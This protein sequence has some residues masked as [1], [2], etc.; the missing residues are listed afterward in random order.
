M[1][2]RLREDYN[3]RV[4]P[5]LMKEKG[6]KNFMSVPTIKKVVLNSGVGEV[7][8]NGQAIEEVAE[9]MTRITGQKAVYTKAKK[10]I[11]AFKIREGLDIGVMVT[12]RGNR[13]W[14]FIDKLV[15]VVLPRTK[16]FRGISATAFDSAGNYSLG[17]KEHTVFPEIDP[18]KVQKIRSLQIVIVTSANNKEDARALLDKFGFPFRK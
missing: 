17:I 6:F 7:T 10:A 13:M 5:E 15:N 3:K 11:A 14:E 2:A 12:L 16:D 9:I 1:I 18:N 8:T 4:R